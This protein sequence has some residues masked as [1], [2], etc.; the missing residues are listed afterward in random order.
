[1]YT[2]LCLTVVLCILLIQLRWEFKATTNLEQSVAGLGEEWK[3]WE[4]KIL[5]YGEKVME[6]STVLATKLQH[7]GESITFSIHA[8]GVVLYTTTL[9][10]VGVSLQANGRHLEAYT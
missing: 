5:E 9:G 4:A 2:I 6:T 7:E 10:S 1:M 8:C 3:K